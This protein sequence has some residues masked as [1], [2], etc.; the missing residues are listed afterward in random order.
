MGAGGPVATVLR[1]AVA[2]RAQA[3]RVPP[4]AGLAEDDRRPVA[5]SRHRARPESDAHA[6]A[7]AAVHSGHHAGRRFHQNRTSRLR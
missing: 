1:T 6:A 3:A 2:G 7:P 5:R 4:V